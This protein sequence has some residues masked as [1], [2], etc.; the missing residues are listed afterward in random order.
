MKMKSTIQL[1]IESGK[2]DA[3]SLRSFSTTEVCNIIK[4]GRPAF[5]VW[6]RDYLSPSIKAPGGRGDSAR[7]SF[8]DLIIIKAFQT[9]I[10]AGVS[11]D[12][13]SFCARYI[14][15]FFDMPSD[16]QEAKSVWYDLFLDGEGK[17]IASDLIINPMPADVKKK[18]KTR[19]DFKNCQVVV[20]VNLTQIAIEVKQAIYAKNQV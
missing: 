5:Q 2:V 13:A 17:F 9:F 3:N 18:P 14:G 16:L 1:L 10:K 11:R 20:G 6:M 19:D 4:I 15:P 12:T 7:W 8:G